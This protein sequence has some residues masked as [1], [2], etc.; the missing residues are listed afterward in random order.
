MVWYWGAVPHVDLKYV[1]TVSPTFLKKKKTLQIHTIYISH[2]ANAGT[3]TREQ[4][5]AYTVPSR[6]PTLWSMKERKERKKE[7]KKKKTWFVDTFLVIKLLF[8][9]FSKYKIMLKA[10]LCEE[11]GLPC[12]GS[13]FHLALEGSHRWSGNSSIIFKLLLSPSMRMLGIQSNPLSAVNFRCSWF[14]IWFHCYQLRLVLSIRSLRAQTKEYTSEFRTSVHTSAAK[15]A[16]TAYG[17][18]FVASTLPPRILRCNTLPQPYFMVD[19]VTHPVRP[20]L[21]NHGFAHRSGFQELSHGRRQGIAVRWNKLCPPQFDLLLNSDDT[22]L[23][24]ITLQVI[25]TSAFQW[26]Y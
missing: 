4:L 6:Y 9:S 8:L 22:D 26:H 7:R 18:S 19:V 11:E 24:P 25:F 1:T 13:H 10:S 3:Q 2:E 5:T 16:V 15:R 23:L 17:T 14:S 20:C 21:R 12:K